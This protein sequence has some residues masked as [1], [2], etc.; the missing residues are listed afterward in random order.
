VTLYRERP[1]QEVTEILK[2]HEA[3][4]AERPISID[5]KVGT[6]QATASTGT[7]SVS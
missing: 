7:L 2:S 1:P 3:D 6:L 5:W 4:T